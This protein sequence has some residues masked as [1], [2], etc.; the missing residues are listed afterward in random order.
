MRTHVKYMFTVASKNHAHYNGTHLV[1][2][3]NP[4]NVL[5]Y[6]VSLSAW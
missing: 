6:R 2:N 5:S 4:K 3:G 1:P